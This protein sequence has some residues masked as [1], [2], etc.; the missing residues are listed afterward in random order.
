[1]SDKKKII[2]ITTVPI[3]L[4]KLLSGQIAFMKEHFEIKAVS[5]EPERL[6]AFGKQQ[7]IDTHAVGLTRKLTPVQDLKALWQLYRYL[8]KEKPFIVH[9]HTPKA[10]TVGMLAAKLAGVPHRLHTVAGL[11]L[12]VAKGK[13]RKL[14]DFVEKITYAAATQVYPNSYGLRDIIVQNGYCAPEKL[15]V[16]ANGSSNGID[17][18]VFDPELFSDKEIQDLRRSLGISPDDV[19]FIFIGRLVR[20]KGIRELVSAF[21]RISA[22]HPKAKLLLVGRYEPDLDPLDEATMTKI[23]SNQNIIETGYQTEIRP[24]FLA[25]DILTFPSYREGFPNVVLQAAAMR[26]PAIVSDINGCN[27]IITQGK[28]GL[29]VPV[30]DENALHEAMLKLLDDSELREKM[31]DSSREEIRKRYEQNFV[32]SAI[33]EEYRSLKA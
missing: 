12:L 9:S 30:A 29:I 7:G 6:S 8:K 19:V 5:S 23:A 4:E 2:R 14:L 13:K 33:L 26:L 28:N 31:R 25:S 27:E 20:D 22:D 10:G 15:T 16:L 32:W 21:D 1:M 18:S 11:P 3:S 24:Y 17:T